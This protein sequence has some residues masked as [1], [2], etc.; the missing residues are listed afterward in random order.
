MLLGGL[1]HGAAWTFVLWGLIHGGALVLTRLLQRSGLPAR[2]PA[3]ARRAIG[4][5]ITFHVVAAAWVFFRAPSVGEALDVFR[6]LGSLDL[7]ALNLGWAAIA[8]LA[9]A[10]L[11]HA[12]PDLW[13][14]KIVNLF[15]K[16]P[17]PVQ[18]LALVGLVLGL[19]QIA[20]AD[21]APFIYFQ[22]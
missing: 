19:R 3:G 17:A 14:D 5:V 12:V 20:A 8:A 2:I 15:H 9:V 6:A 4:V 16:I 7:T 1:W 10:A 11:T 13:T 18:A 22:F 21:V